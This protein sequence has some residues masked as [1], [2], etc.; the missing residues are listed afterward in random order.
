M[1]KCVSVKSVSGISRAAKRK[2]EETTK[3]STRILRYFL[4]VID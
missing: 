3:E 1:I 2:T 4:L